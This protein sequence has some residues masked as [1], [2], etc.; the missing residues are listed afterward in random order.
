MEKIKVGIIGP[1]NIGTDLMFKVLKSKNLEMKMMTGIVESE[2]L[3]RAKEMGFEVSTEGAKAV[4]EDPEIKIV[5]E[6]TSAPA[7]L[8]NA[9]ILKAAGKVC[10][11]MTPAAVGPYVVPCVNL[12]E[13]GDEVDDYNMVTCGG[14]ATVPIVSAINA[15]ADVEYA[16]IVASISSKSA[17]PGTR[18]NIDEFTQTTA[19]ALKVVGGADTSKAIIVLNPAEP[20]VMMANT[21]YCRIKNKDEDA[22][23]KSVNDMVKKIQSYV[24][25]YTLRVPPIF[26]DD[27][28]TVIAQVIGAGDFLPEYSGNLDIINCAA[29]G[30][31]EI[32]AERMLKGVR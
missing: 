6:A 4:A 16:E 25:G 13:L 21:I 23:R 5:F 18:A 10:F 12:D 31:A 11:D 28:V 24:P 22:I 17:G 15:V 29:V 9:P 27:R 32:V 8:E 30:A 19:N 20:P 7:H 2:G 3:T 1:G 26:D 14:Q